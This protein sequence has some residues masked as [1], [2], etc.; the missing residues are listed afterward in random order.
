[1]SKTAFSIIIPCY[2]VEKYVEH[3]VEKLQWQ[4]YRD[5][6]IIL[7]D[8]GSTD[9]TFALCQK[10]EQIYGN[11]AVITHNYER[12][13]ATRNR[14]LEATRNRGLEAAS[15]E[16]IYF[17]DADDELQD[18]ALQKVKESFECDPEIDMVLTGLA[19][20]YEDARPERPV[21][22][23]LPAGVYSAADIARSALDRIP[24]SVMSCVGS[25]VYRREFIERNNMRFDIQYKFN[26]DGAFAI[27]A[28]WKA[29]K[30][31]YLPEPIYRYR[32]RR[33]SIMHSYR[34]N[35]FVSLNRV[36]NLQAAY[37]VNYGVFTQ[38]ETYV[39]RGR[40][41][42]VQSLLVEEA[43]YKGYRSFLEL[44]DKL[45]EDPDVR[46]TCVRH[47]MVGGISPGSRLLFFLFRHHMGTAVYGLIKLH[48]HMG[49]V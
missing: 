18:N 41:S 20:I 34:E 15:G 32:Q 43:N 33:G 49:G 30:I 38:K 12:Q 11:V 24:W 28:F 8:D 29:R 22:A 21:L 36:L 2:N 16:W 13:E 35:A 5:M 27:Q 23:R 4:S 10:M 48:D 45:F 3:C 37:F 26:E 1:M 14:G 6:E 39:L 46:T 40:W 17:L 31:M 25:K 42:M 9:D 19:F 7:I 47:S 44:F